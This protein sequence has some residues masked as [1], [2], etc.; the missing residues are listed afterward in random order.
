MKPILLLFVT[1]LHQ[2]S[3]TT[4][5]SNK[6]C[7]SWWATLLYQHLDI[8]KKTVKIQCTVWYVGSV[9]FLINSNTHNKIKSVPSTWQNSKLISSC[10]YVFV[11]QM[12]YKY[13]FVYGITFVSF[14]WDVY[15]LVF[16]LRRCLSH[17]N[18]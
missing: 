15:F 1:N 16:F 12:L 3:V 18:R 10:N 5:I 17:V 6:T 2:Q 7:V 14:L 13:N 9:E 8:M 4:I 11:L